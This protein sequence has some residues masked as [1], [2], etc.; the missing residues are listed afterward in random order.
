MPRPKARSL[1]LVPV[2]ARDIEAAAHRCRKAV[3]KRALISAT[4]AVVP[5][6]GIDLAVD[7][8]VLMKM[9][10]EI[11][12]EFGLTPEQ[13]EL[14]APKR[15]LSAYKAIAAVGSSVVGRAI[16]REAL[17]LIVKS[18]AKRLATKTTVKFLP[19]AGQAIAA[20]ISFAAIKYIGDAHVDDCV[21]VAQAISSPRA[22]ARKRD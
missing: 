14:L 20:T 7:V 15:R 16:T 11:N 5:I 2:A 8:G 21:A 19:L 12:S 1:A 18:V 22:R 17:S 10:Q 6:P 9:L 13:I 4:A 3:M